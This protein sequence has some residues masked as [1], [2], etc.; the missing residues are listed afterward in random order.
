MDIDAIIAANDPP[1]T[2]TGAIKNAP[3][4]SSFFRKFDPV[5]TASILAGLQTFPHHQANYRLEWAARLAL[6]SGSGTA[7]PNPP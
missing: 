7:L 6:A 4:L 1:E 3:K 2:P 5:G